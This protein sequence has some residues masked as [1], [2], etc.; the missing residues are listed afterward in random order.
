M[1]TSAFVQ[2]QQERRMKEKLQLQNKNLQLPCET[3]SVYAF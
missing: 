1:I 3:K 2:E